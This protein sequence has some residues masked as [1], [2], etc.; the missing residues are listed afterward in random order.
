MA[1]IARHIKAAE[2]GLGLEGRFKGA[3]SEKEGREFFVRY[4]NI[5]LGSS[6]SSRATNAYLAAAKK[7]GFRAIK[8]D[9]L[10]TQIVDK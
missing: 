10:G 9:R 8:T 1:T 5:S 6:M 4:I 7:H 3:P 2:Q